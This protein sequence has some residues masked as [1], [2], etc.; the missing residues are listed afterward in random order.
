[1]SLL[2]NKVPAEPEAGCH[3]ARQV[4]LL[5]DAGVRSEPQKKKNS[6]ASRQAKC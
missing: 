1:M 2:F 6:H 3:P 4:A 5:A